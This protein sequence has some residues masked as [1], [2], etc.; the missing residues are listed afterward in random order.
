M[1]TTRT[2]M[3]KRTFTT[4]DETRP[5][6]RG[7]GDTVSIANATFTR[8]TL[9]PGWRWSSDVKPITNTHSCQATHTGVVLAGKLH[10]VMDDGTEMDLE[11]GD[12]YHIPPGHDAW[13]VGDESYVGVEVA[14]DDRWAK[15]SA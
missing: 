5:A 7:H 11:A 12:T 6:G 10:T 14:G 4:P 2:Q 13:V 15:P 3:Q 1:A 9:E 8:I